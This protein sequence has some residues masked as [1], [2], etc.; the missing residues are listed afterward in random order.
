MIFERKQIEKKIAFIHYP[1]GPKSARLETMPFA[2]NSVIA[3]AKAGW[4]I[5]LYLWERPLW[6]KPASNYGSLLPKNVKIQ[7]FTELRYSPVDRW[8]DSWLKFRFGHRDRYVCVFGLG[9]KG[10][11]IGSV[12]AKAS[13]CP[14]IQILDEFPSNWPADSLWSQLERQAARE[15]AML[16]I[17]DA[18]QYPL[19][20][21]ELDI[22]PTIPHAALPNVAAVDVIDEQINWHDKLGLPEHSIPFLYAG[23][24]GPWAQVP[25]LLSTVSDWPEPAVLVVH[26]RSPHEIKKFRQQYPHLEVANR[27]FWSSEPLPQERLNPLVSYCEANFA[28]Y[29]NS[30][31]HIEYIGFSSGKLMRSLACGSPVIA[32]NLTSFAFVTEHNLGVL[33][34]ELSEIPDAVK[35]IMGKRQEYKKRCLEFCQLHA[36]FEAHW[37]GFC[38]K[39]MAVTQIDLQ[40]PIA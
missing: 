35:Q 11:F 7:Y 15:A 37:P 12:M 29:C 25:E 23:T 20:C 30:G 33:V 17:P 1:H 16:V 32:S 2:L 39:F 28:L 38:E 27:I 21:Q 36:S 31:P 10:A 6:G 3:L 24:V 22:P 18:Q 26:S 8:I 13:Q 14:F 9:Q 4:C 19:L 5:D 34:K 40:K